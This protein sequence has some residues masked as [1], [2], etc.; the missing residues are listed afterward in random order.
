MI[1]HYRWL[2][3]SNRRAVLGSLLLGLPA[4][5]LSALGLSALG[6]SALGLSALGCSEDHSPVKQ[7]CPR[8][9]PAFRVQLVAPGGNIPA[10]TKLQVTFGGSGREHYSVERGN[11]DNKTVCC[12]PGEVLSGDYPAVKC[13]DSGGSGSE[14]GAGVAAIHC[15]MWTD[16]AAEVEVEA[17]GYSL[18]E[19]TLTAEL[20]DDE[21][22]E[23]CSMLTTKDV[24]ISLLRG[25]AGIDD[26]D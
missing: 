16:G 20:S 1:K 7:P 3:A 2:A 25:D 6:L 9:V 11:G 15:E 10:N 22:L 4:L 5:G 19:E 21:Q 26:D 8:D 12:R 23:G 24:E 18:L 13:D 14:A 17:D